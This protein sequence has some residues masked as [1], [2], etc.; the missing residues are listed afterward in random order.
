MPSRPEKRRDAQQRDGAER[1]L[2][3]RWMSAANSSVTQVYEQGGTVNTITID[4]SRCK[5]DGLCT[6]VCSKGLFTQLE[7]MNPQEYAT[8]K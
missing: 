6:R 4:R 3:L 5:K 2:A 1:G 7:K 8:Q